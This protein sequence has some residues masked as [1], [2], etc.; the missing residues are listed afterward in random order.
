MFGGE[1]RH[2]LDAKN[3][4]FIPAKMREDLG[5]TFV[6]VKDIRAKCLKLYSLAGWTEYLEPIRKLERKLRER[7]MRVLNASMV[8]VSPDLQ[9]RITLVKDHV[10]YAEID[11][12]A[13]VVGCFDYA[14]IW[15]EE[16][17]DRMKASENTTELLAEL[18]ALGL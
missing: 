18:E 17:Y 4:I 7:T 10:D 12:C 8:Q 6:V 3:R 16:A 2:T 1:Y 15:A 5:A 13:V 11:K 14:E 9:G